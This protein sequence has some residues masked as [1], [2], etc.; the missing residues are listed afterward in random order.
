MR[1]VWL[2]PCSCGNLLGCGWIDPDYQ[3]PPHSEI[4]EGEMTERLSEPCT[5]S[6]D[7]STFISPDD[8]P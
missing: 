2:L 7:I 5:P 3:P 4:S 1:D 8:F 6:S